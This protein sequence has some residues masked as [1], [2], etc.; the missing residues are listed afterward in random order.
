[1]SADSHADALDADSYADVG[2]GPSSASDTVLSAVA[3]RKSLALARTL[4]RKRQQQQQQQQALQS[5]PAAAS[6]PDVEYLPASAAGDRD[7]DYDRDLLA[8]SPATNDSVHP[9]SVAARVAAHVRKSKSH[10]VVSTFGLTS[11]S[12]TIATPVSPAPITPS[13]AA[14]AEHAT[15]TT[16]AHNTDAQYAVYIAHTQAATIAALEA[17]KKNLLAQLSAR[18]RAV[19]EAKSAAAQI[20]DLESRV[21]SFERELSRAKEHEREL[22][23]KIKNISAER[24]EL[25]QACS[26]MVVEDAKKSALLKKLQDDSD[27]ANERFKSVVDKII[28]EKELENGS[29][30]RSKAELEEMI[31]HLREENMN[32][33]AENQALKEEN[34]KNE[35]LETMSQNQKVDNT[36]ENTHFKFPP[37]SSSAIDIIHLLPDNGNLEIQLLKQRALATQKSEIQRLKEE[38]NSLRAQ[39]AE[40]V[41]FMQSY[42]LIK[43]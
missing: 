40:A 1:M 10:A 6:V 21:A 37:R 20:S 16:V 2:E 14:A 12:G 39:Y 25:I 9:V 3:A 22:A 43:Q 32:L 17:D 31:K 33:L 8:G 34:E 42:G 19:A 15:T 29:T 7:S 36:K 23:D 24:A 35:Q 4:S 27:R 11:D 28:T 18:D 30:K 13:S 5:A 41:E 26:A 38:N